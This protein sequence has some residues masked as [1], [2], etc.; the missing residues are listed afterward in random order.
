MSA[1]QVSVGSLNVRSILKDAHFQ[2]T[3]SYAHFLRKSPTIK[4]DILCLQE[5]THYHENQ[6]LQDT[7][8][9][10][11]LRLF[12]QSSCLLSRYCAILCLN[13]NLMLSNETVSV[14]ERVL[15]SSIIDK[16]SSQ[17]ICNI[18]NIYGPAKRVDKPAFYQSLLQHP[19]LTHGLSQWIL[20]GD[21][22][23]Q[24][25]SPRALP[26]DIRP[27]NQW[28]KDNFMDIHRQQ[29][30]ATGNTY[31]PLPTFKRGAHR[32]T[33]DFVF[34]THDLQH[35]ISNAKQQ[36]L[37]SQWTDHALL[38]FTFTTSIQPKGP[39][40]WRFNNQLLRD[41]DFTDLLDKLLKAFFD[42]GKGSHTSRQDQWESLKVRIKGCAM[43][44]STDKN[45]E[46]RSTL[47]HLQQQRTRYL[48]NDDPDTHSTEQLS[49]L[50]QQIE[51]ETDVLTER[52]VIRSHSTW[53]EKGERSNKYFFRVLKQ[54]TQQVNMNRIRDPATGVIHDTPASMLSAAKKFYGA[55]YTPETSDPYATDQ[56]LQSVSRNQLN[57][58]DQ[59]A[60]REPLTMT[61]LEELIAG[62]PLNKSPGLDGLTFEVYKYISSHHQPTANLL[63]NVLND[64]LDGLI[65]RSW[66][67]TRMVMLYKKGDRDLLANWRPLSMINTDA[68]L[69][70]KL[71][72]NRF[73]KHMARIINPYQTGF[74]HNRLISD[75]GWITQSLMAHLQHT[76]KDN[77][78][79]GILLDQEK[80]YDRVH[81]DYLHKTML[82]M[83]FPDQIVDLI[84]DLFFTTKIHIS[85]NGWLAAPITQARGLRQGDP[86]SPLLFNIAFEP[87]LR[88]LLSHSSLHGF[89]IP[90]SCTRQTR[91]SLQSTIQIK[92]LAYADD[93]LIFLRS[94]GEWQS[95]QQLLLTYSEASNAK[96]NL[97]KTTM[98][99][100]TGKHHEEWIS[101]AREQGFQWHDHSSPEAVTYLGYPLYTGSHQVA[102]RLDDIRGK[103]IRHIQILQSRNLSVLGRAL[104]AN[105][106]ILSR[107]W[108]VLR[109][110]IVKD[111][112]LQ[113]IRRLVREYVLPFHPK[114]AIDLAYLP[115]Q[116]GGLGLINI[117]H[118]NLALHN[119]YLHRMLSYVHNNP[120]TDVINVLV[121]IYTKHRC[122]VPFL[123]YPQGFH[124][125]LRPIPQLQHI[126]RLL[127]ALPAITPDA[128]WSPGFT[129]YIPLKYAIQTNDR[130]QVLIKSIQMPYIIQHLFDPPNPHCPMFVPKYIPRNSRIISSIEQD[131]QANRTT[132][133]PKIMELLDNRYDH[134]LPGRDITED[135]Q[136]WTL[137]TRNT[138]TTPTKTYKGSTREYRRFWQATNDIKP[139][140]IPPYAPIPRERMSKHQWHFFWS[141]IIPHNVR[142]FWWRLLLN[143][144]PTRLHRHRHQPL[145]CPTDTCSLCN[146]ATEDNY[147]MVVGCPLKQ[148]FWRY[149]LTIM[150]IQEDVSTIWNWLTFYELPRNKAG[151]EQYRGNL[152]MLG[153]ALTIIWQLH[154]RSV[155][156]DEPWSDQLAAS[157]FRLLLWKQGKGAVLE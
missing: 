44:Y 45:R 128:A 117:Q 23:L 94:P 20:L 123:V 96:M 73:Q 131:L 14:D 90:D 16:S 110:T 156:G 101:I 99:S 53:L 124:Q 28:L 142:N 13:P 33:I 115:K 35:K 139:T 8:W 22:N 130:S 77:P 108:H 3:T 113:Q 4:A 116:Q 157:S 67:E 5:V 66:K 60:L 85:L 129:K 32:S 125:A 95:L 133:T 152:T 15:T 40:V 104:T 153:K 70:T 137:P 61:S 147:H 10:S 79:V 64:A 18:A 111:S 89:P 155:L 69:F 68:K 100:L 109:V 46:R 65:P 30:T 97:S 88:T 34:A 6:H 25:Y 80:A 17:I 143:K 91:L 98:L 102:Q 63:L 138:T 29:D 146:T 27:W 144:L 121:K 72:A 7:H 112:W 74:L 54:R 62:S 50:E 39:G 26:A 48:S 24:L 120:L 58:N 148:T 52:M 135:L 43:L 71:L 140:L 38:S 57:A 51:D 92:F 122:I 59:T 41:S 56:L 136:H 37:P 82:H 126:G 93:L 83:G 103:I 87:M 12:P 75:N 107:L 151:L 150:D 76:D 9:D 127:Q 141:L 49:K 132:W 47:Q 145:Q 106:L 36:Y 55:L 19:M 86:L 1:Q 114:P 21:L 81:P 11:I 154:W 31:K 134:R 118:Q 84:S 105:S 78:A 2:T 119:V 149:V 42:D